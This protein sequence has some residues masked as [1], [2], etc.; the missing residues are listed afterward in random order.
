M[1]TD[2]QRR[3][4]R[5]ATTNLCFVWQQQHLELQFNV[6]LSVPLFA[7]A[8]VSVS[9][10]CGDLHPFAATFARL[11]LSLPLVLSLSLLCLLLP[12]RHHHHHH[13]NSVGCQGSLWWCTTASPPTSATN[14]PTST[15]L[16]CFSS[17][18]ERRSACTEEE[19]TR[20]KKSDCPFLQQQ[21]QQRP[22]PV[23]LTLL[24]FLFSYRILERSRNGF[25]NEKRR[26][27]VV[28][29]QTLSLPVADLF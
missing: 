13:H 19:E 23:L 15:T 7:F 27:F 20:K 12:H 6:G 3:P 1:A 8:A 25:Q 28:V 11:F 4:R 5:L 18:Q 16:W 21:Q 22:P 29:P 17:R 26:A 10:V 24:F 14:E 9:V 2:Y